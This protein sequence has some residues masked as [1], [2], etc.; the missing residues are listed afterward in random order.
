M[1]GAKLRVIA[2][3][4]LY[5]FFAGVDRLSGKGIL[6]K[7]AQTEKHPVYFTIFTRICK[8]LLA[9]KFSGAGANKHDLPKIYL[10]GKRITADLL[11]ML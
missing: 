4:R 7:M 1:A 11:H 9:E 2:A 10:R 3:G 6:L 8:A 5:G